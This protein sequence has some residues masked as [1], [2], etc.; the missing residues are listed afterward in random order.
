MKFN[1]FTDKIVMPV[2]HTKALF[3]LHLPVQ[4]VH[5]VGG[6]KAYP[7]HSNHVSQVVFVLLTLFDSITEKI[8]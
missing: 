1:L 5:G 3:R 6:H 4:L 8:I 2:V 7:K